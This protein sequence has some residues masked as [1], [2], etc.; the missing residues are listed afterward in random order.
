MRPCESP[1]ENVMLKSGLYDADGPPGGGGGLCGV[2]WHRSLI[3]NLLGDARFGVECGDQQR[4][5][6]GSRVS[7]G[8]GCDISVAGELHTGFLEVLRDKEEDEESKGV[9]RTISTSLQ[10][11][12]VDVASNCECVRCSLW[13][14]S[15]VGR[16]M[17]V[18]SGTNGTKARH[19]IR[20]RGEVSS[21]RGLA[22]VGQLPSE[23]V[24]LRLDVSHVSWLTDLAYIIIIWTCAGEPP[25]SAR[26]HKS[27]DSVV[28][29][30]SYYTGISRDTAD[31]WPLQY[32]R[33]S[34]VGRCVWAFV[35]RSWEHMEG[36]ISNSISNEPVWT[37]C[38]DDVTRTVHL[39]SNMDMS[40]IT[41]CTALR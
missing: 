37:M 17:S 38:D 23:R 11:S 36:R 18:Q 13:L 15:N 40:S 12:I 24:I 34:S 33:C 31:I 9:T 22:C 19:S 39:N 4:L 29:G 8:Y 1:V 25:L 21:R 20:Q 10:C 32:L 28:S 14:Q 6:F 2:S 7:E 30:Q 41:I 5:S 3:E 35:R 27:S 16:N 26:L